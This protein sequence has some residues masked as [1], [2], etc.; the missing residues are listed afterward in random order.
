MYTSYWQ[1]KALPF[2][3][4]PDPAFF[5]ASRIHEEGLA[6]LVYAV[7]Q[8]K[9]AAMVVGAIG[10]GKTMLAQALPAQLPARQYRIVQMSNPALDPLDFLQMVL[11]LFDVPIKSNPTKAQMLNALESHLRR[12]QEK[13][14]HAVLV[15]DEAQTIKN[16]DTMDELRML[17]NLQSSTHVLLNLV[18][19]GQEELEASLALCPYLARQLSICFRPGPL[20]AMDTYRYIQ[21]R[22]KVAGAK[23]FPFTFEAVKRIYRYSRGVPRNINNLGDRSLLAAYIRK[24][25]VVDSSTID[26]AWRDLQ[27][28]VSG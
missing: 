8:G 23:T 6:R 15:V 1:M 27:E 16:P 2:E 11:L 28:S 3:N 10:C 13:G 21:Y 14:I 9:G 19:L 20:S 12:E 26:D 5:Y 24:Q 25:K 17:L 7:R 18:L 22:V 4:R